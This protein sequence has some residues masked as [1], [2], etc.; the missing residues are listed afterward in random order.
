MDRELTRSEE[1][2]KE[3]KV[4]EIWI[5][6]WMHSNMSVNKSKMAGCYNVRGGQGVKGREEEQHIRTKPTTGKA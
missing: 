1:C 2:T 3:G 5:G 4:F 6:V